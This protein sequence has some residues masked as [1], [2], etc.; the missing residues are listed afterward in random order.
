MT[1]G[2]IS[3]EKSLN[4]LSLT[5]GVA[6]IIGRAVI[7]HATTDN[8]TTNGVP[9]AGSR[10]ARCVIGVGNNSSYPVATWGDVLSTAN[11]ATNRMPLVLIIHL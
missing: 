2:V 7:L 8:C 4:L 11:Q 10:I 3:Q 1:G 9:S 6:S 5:D